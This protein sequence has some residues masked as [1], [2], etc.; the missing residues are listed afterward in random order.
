MDFTT[1]NWGQAASIVSGLLLLV[2]VV[3]AVRVRAPLGGWI[4]GLAHLIVASLNSAA[5]FR[6]VLDPG[7]IGYGFGLLTGDQGWD[8]ATTAGAVLLTAI[9]G[10][11]SAL[12]RSRE[13]MLVTLVTSL[14]FLV[15]L[16]WPWLQSVISGV[17]YVFQLGEYVTVP[18]SVAKGLLFVISVAP[19]LFGVVWA[20]LHA[21]RHPPAV[22]ETPADEA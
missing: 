5:P 21:F 16:G 19:F 18:S 20:A 22:V 9:V 4:V 12:R 2:W 13:A 17:D 3:T 10:A 1:F 6:S 7:Y 15:V 11:F 14:L 8:V